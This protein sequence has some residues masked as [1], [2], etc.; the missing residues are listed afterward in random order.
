M[1]ECLAD[2]LD[3]PLTRPADYPLAQLDTVE[4]GADFIARAQAL[5]IAETADGLVLAMADPTD[6]YTVKA[7]RL[8]AGRPVVPWAA[9]PSEL[10]AAIARICGAAAEKGIAGLNGNNGLAAAPARDDVRRLSDFA[11]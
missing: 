7:V 9:V 6:D 4:L 2:F 8:A 10:T 11:S 3:I 5:P 1:A